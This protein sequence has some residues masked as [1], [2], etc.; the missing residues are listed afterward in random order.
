MHSFFKSLFRRIVGDGSPSPTPIEGMSF[1]EILE[2]VKQLPES[3]TIQHG[4]ALTKRLYEIALYDH[5]VSEEHRTGAV[6]L[7]ET[8]NETVEAVMRENPQALTAY[9]TAN[10]YMEEN[11]HRIGIG[12]LAWLIEEHGVPPEQIVEF[13]ANSEYRHLLNDFFSVLDRATAEK[14]KDELEQYLRS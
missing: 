7:L 6:K 13:I 1:L 8:V 14:V 2:H 3:I 9:R 11:A 12:S 4:T 5:H 10:A